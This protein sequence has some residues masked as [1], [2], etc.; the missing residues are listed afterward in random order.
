MTTERH[1]HREDNRREVLRWL[2]LL[3]AEGH[4]A[5]PAEPRPELGLAWGPDGR[6]IDI[7][8]WAGPDE[9][10]DSDAEYS[11]GAE[12]S[13]V[14]EHASGDEHGGGA[15]HGPSGGVEGGA[16]EEGFEVSEGERFS[17]GA[18]GGGAARER[19]AS[20]GVNAE[21]APGGDA[22]PGEEVEEPRAGAG[23]ASDVA[24]RM[25]GPEST[26]TSGEREGASG[27]MRGE[28]G[29][30]A[31][32]HPVGS[33]ADGEAGTLLETDQEAGAGPG[34]EA[35]SDSA[36]NLPLGEPEQKM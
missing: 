17:A 16:A 24:E 4:R 8:P 34:Q 10:L 33:A 29:A 25:E 9:V 12:Y 5:Y 3:I 11:S 30:A 14:A 28:L 20:A 21:E 26:D 1:A 32:A 27:S 6:R 31:A 7:Q 13:D 35:R 2:H 22:A 36:E 18:C 15:E 19:D 23:L